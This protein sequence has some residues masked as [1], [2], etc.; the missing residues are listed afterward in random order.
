[1]ERN[2]IILMRAKYLRTMRSN[3]KSD[4]PRPVVF[5]DDTW[6]N[7][8]HSVKKSWNLNDDQHRD[9]SGGHTVP[10]GLGGRLII[11][12]AGSKEGWVPNALLTFKANSSSG[13]YHDN[14]NGE[15]FLKWLR[16]QL[17]PNPSPRQCSISQRFDGKTAHNPN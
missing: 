10:P 3:R 12:H 5:Q 2:D 16:E 13:D 1:M 9:M 15:N 14:M 8:H 17:I 4:S 11:N 7:A 6:L